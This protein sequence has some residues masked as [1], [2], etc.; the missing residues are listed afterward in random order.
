MI[1]TSAPPPTVSSNSLAVTA[2]ST[3]VSPATANHP[4][5][6]QPVDANA[7]SALINI[8]FPPRPKSSTH[9]PKDRLL[10]RPRFS[11]HRNVSQSRALATW[12]SIML[13]RQK[14]I[15][16]DP[17]ITFDQLDL[18]FTLMYKLA[19]S[20]QLLDPPTPAI[21]VAFLY[22][23]RAYPDGITY[24][25]NPDDECVTAL[26]RIFLLCMRLALQWYDDQSEMFDFRGRRYRSHVS[27][28]RHEHLD[29]EKSLFRSADVDLL[30]LLGHNLCVSNIAYVRWLNYIQA[31]L[32]E[33]LGDYI[34]EHDSIFEL[35]SSIRPPLTPEFLGSHC[36]S[37]TGLPLDKRWYPAIRD[38]EEF[39]DRGKD[40]IDC[41][42]VGFSSRLHESPGPE[43]VAEPDPGPSGKVT[44]DSDGNETND[45][46]TNSKSQGTEGEP[47]DKSSSPCVPT[48]ILSPAKSSTDSL[49]EVLDYINTL[50]AKHSRLRKSQGPSYLS[51]LLSTAETF[52]NGFRWLWSLVWG[53]DL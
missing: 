31:T 18:H 17:G 28:Q 38:I 50:T 6:S 46:N 33:V 16:D 52:L 30:H 29:L 15:L 42:C 13:V 23:C 1:P 9:R 35:I 10:P 20:F 3:I 41:L 43:K 39:E 44:T 19:K 53:M 24:S 11:R 34:E 14:L 2:S 49:A 48:P 40:L 32:P 8:V 26:W 27:L 5:F 36:L 22:L 37:C 47:S 12:L 25:G 21:L 4:D 51:P 7:T 45:S